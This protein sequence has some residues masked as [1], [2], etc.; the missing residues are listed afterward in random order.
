MI[1]FFD[2]TG[3]IKGTIDGRIHPPHQLKMGPLDENGKMY[4]KIVVEWKP[5]GLE[6]I[7]IVEEDI[8]EDRLDEEGYTIS[9]KIGTRKRKII[10]QIFEPDHPQKSIFMAIDEGKRHIYDFKIDLDT[11]TLVEK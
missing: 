8:L 9:V 7:D 2:D 3:E 4:R 5:T 10:S 1:I 11:K 6:R